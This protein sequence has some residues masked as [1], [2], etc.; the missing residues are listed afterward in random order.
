MQSGVPATWVTPPRADAS[1]RGAARVSELIELT[2]P[3]HPE[4]LDGGLALLALEK[5][6]NQVLRETFGSPELAG[7]HRRW[8]LEGLVSGLCDSAA[9]A[10]KGFCHLTDSDPLE[11]LREMTGAAAVNLGD[12]DARAAAAR[13]IGVLTEAIMHDDEVGALWALENLFVVDPTVTPISSSAVTERLR[14]V[15]NAAVC[16]CAMSWKLFAAASD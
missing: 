15:F 5:L 12:G 11:E 16:T 9:Y 14:D 6:L 10:M 1:R 3:P 13:A 4:D 7:D 8:Y 2:L